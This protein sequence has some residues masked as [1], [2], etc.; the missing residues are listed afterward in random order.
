MPVADEHTFFLPIKP[1]ATQRNRCGC[2]S[3]YPTSYL[4]PK[5]RAWK[6]EAITLLRGMARP[7]PEDASFDG[8]V[9]VAVE[10]VVARP[11]TTKK[12]R[13]SG[14]RDNYEKGVFDAITQ[15]GGWWKDDDQ[16]VEGPFLKRWARPG[17][18]EG[19]RLTIR[20]RP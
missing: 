15:A 19:Y 20:F 4:D 18:E 12:V 17:E 16:V 9:Y 3:R 8:D 11:K 14:D 7:F 13:P 6:D 1:N 2:R 5:Y 10:V